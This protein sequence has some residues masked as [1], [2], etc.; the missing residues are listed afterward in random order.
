MS[1]FLSQNRI[2]IIYCLIVKKNGHP[3]KD[4]RGGY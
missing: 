3:V 2:N 1:S 4:A